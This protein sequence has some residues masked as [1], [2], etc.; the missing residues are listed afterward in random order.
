M[1]TTIETYEIEPQS[2]EI[3]QLAADGEHKMLIDQL[4]L[5]G[6]QSLLAAP[7]SES[8]DSAFPYPALSKI[9]HRVFEFHCPQKTKLKD[10]RGDM[11]PLRVLQVAAHALTYGKLDH[12]RVWHPDNAKLD[13]VLVGYTTNYGG[14]LFL[15]ARWGEVWKNF[16]VLLSEAVEGYKKM[17]AAKLEKA[18]AELTKL[19]NCA[20]ADAELYC[21]G[22]NI[23]NSINFGLEK[24]LW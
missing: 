23:D 3:A 11:I 7:D 18:Q 6:Q 21:Q 20:K 8:A 14:N 1:N 22:E 13:P 9:Q 24:P 16:D 2:S 5:V 15:L 17:R 19:T 10:Y 12:V 4:E